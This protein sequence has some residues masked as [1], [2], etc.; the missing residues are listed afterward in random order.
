MSNLTKEE[1]SQLLR[2]T[3]N[4]LIKI[5][6]KVNQN[7]HDKIELEEN[8]KTF[9]APVISRL[10]EN[11]QEDYFNPQF[12]AIGYNSPEKKTSKHLAIPD[13]SQDD[14][15]FSP[16]ASPNLHKPKKRK[17]MQRDQL[18]GSIDFDA[19]V[20]ATMNPGDGF[21]EMLGL[22][23][24]NDIYYDLIRLDPVERIKQLE[25]YEKVIV[26]FLQR[27]AKSLGGKKKPKSIWKEEE[28]A[29][30]LMDDDLDEHERAEFELRLQVIR[31]Q[32]FVN[33]YRRSFNVLKI[34]IQNPSI[35]QIQYGTG[36]QMFN[37]LDELVDRLVLIRGNIIGG[38][39]S[40][41]IINEARAITDLLY[42]HKY[43]KD[44]E[45]KHLYSIFKI[46]RQNE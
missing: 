18:H 24:L 14:I 33:Q 11:N 41:E 9:H 20:M 31:Q 21:Y 2:D 27:Y 15:F 13:E 4:S 26:P 29:Q 5:R 40:V 10:E 6:N 23:K 36:C 3:H 45:Y 22:K 32:I 25:S 46:T 35:V 38:N 8:L 1:Y 39:N 28:L 37:N 7:K 44:K 16:A 17:L 34:N 30:M 43:L 12:H 19:P 42:R